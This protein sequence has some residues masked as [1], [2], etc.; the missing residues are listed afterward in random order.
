VHSIT[1]TTH[2]IVSAGTLTYDFQISTLI[3]LSYHDVLFIA[4][5]FTLECSTFSAWFRWR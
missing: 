4:L 2:L 5:A 3:K 1:R